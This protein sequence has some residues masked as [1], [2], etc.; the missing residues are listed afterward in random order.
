VAEDLTPVDLTAY[1]PPECPH[2]HILRYG[3]REDA[4]FI[5][6]RVQVSFT[7]CDCPPARTKGGSWGHI[8]VECSACRGEGRVTRLLDPPCSAVGD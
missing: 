5:P 7:T 3:G 1:C 2:G 4:A 6:G 8:S